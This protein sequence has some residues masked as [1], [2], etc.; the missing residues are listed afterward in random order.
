MHSTASPSKSQPANPG[1][2]VPD[3]WWTALADRFGTKNLTL[4][5]LLTQENVL[6]GGFFVISGYASCSML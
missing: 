1:S 5:K 4:L 3:S 6:V 2:E